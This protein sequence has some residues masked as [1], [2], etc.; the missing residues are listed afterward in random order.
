MKKIFDYLYAIKTS[1]IYGFQLCLICFEY[2]F[3]MFFYRRNNQYLNSSYQIEDDYHLYF[4]GFLPESD[5][6]SF[7]YF[8]DGHV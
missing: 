6:V 2:W 3:G 8:C 7:L 5:S 4:W 1:I